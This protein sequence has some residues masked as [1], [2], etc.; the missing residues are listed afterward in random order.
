MVTRKTLPFIGDNVYDIYFNNTSY[1][2]PGNHFLE[3][4]KLLQSTKSFLFS[5]K[6][7]ITQNFLQRIL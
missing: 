3:H 5:T 2:N 4:R 6:H 7:F 1:K